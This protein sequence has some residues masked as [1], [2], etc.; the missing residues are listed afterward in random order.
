MGTSVRW[1]VAKL[2]VLAVGL[3]LLASHD[4]GRAADAKRPADLYRAVVPNDMYTQARQRRG[5]ILAR[6]GRQGRRQEDGQQGPVNC[7]H[8]CRLRPR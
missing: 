5:Q 3:G 7:S 1:R 6:R 2:A 8:D 4:S